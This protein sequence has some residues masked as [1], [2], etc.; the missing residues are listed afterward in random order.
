[1][2]QFVT[3]TVAMMA[4]LSSGALAQTPWDKVASALG[5][6]GAQMPGDVYRVPLPRTD[7]K[8]AGDGVDIRPG[9]ALGGWIAFHAMGSG[10]MVMG[11]LVLTETEIN[12]VMSKLFAGGRTVT[13]M[14][15]PLLRA[16]PARF[17]RH[18]AVL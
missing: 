7:L 10:A 15:N 11:D 13:A 16:Q 18:L 2:I 3:A 6:P 5:K 8:V 1:M 14:H 17:Y 4:L 12:P 9:F